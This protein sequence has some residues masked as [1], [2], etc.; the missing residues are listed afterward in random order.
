MQIDWGVWVLLLLLGIAGLGA[1]ILISLWLDGICHSGQFFC[2]LIP[3]WMGLPDNRD[4]IDSFILTILFTV[5]LAR[6]SIAQK[7]HQ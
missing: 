5:L 7:L 2:K 3:K 4:R 6:E 1:V